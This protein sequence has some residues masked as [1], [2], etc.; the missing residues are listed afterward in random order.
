MSFDIE[1]T[2]SYWREGAEYDLGTAEALFQA[3]KYP[4]ALFFGHLALEKLFKALVVKETG[5]HAPYTHSLPFLAT[6]LS[7]KIPVEV[8]A[9]FPI[10]MEFYSEGRYPEERVQF[11]R[12]CTKEFT[13]QNLSEIKKVFQWLSEK[14]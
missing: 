5:E 3:G 2:I 9:K 10:F 11:Y 1:K 4:Y 14:L 8:A 12:K 6:K 13:L 7:L